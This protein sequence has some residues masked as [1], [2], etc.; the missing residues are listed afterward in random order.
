MDWIHDSRYDSQLNQDQYN[1]E[2]IY[3]PDWDELFKETEETCDKEY[4]DLLIDS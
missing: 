3:Y 2:D 4:M 1:D